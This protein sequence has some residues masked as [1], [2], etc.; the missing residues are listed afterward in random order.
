[1]AKTIHTILLNDTIA[2][3]RIVSMDNCVCQLYIITRGDDHTLSAFVDELAQPAL[4][5]LLN[6]ETRE[7]YVGETDNFPKR[8]QNHSKAKDFWT[9]AMAFFA[10]DKSLTKTEVQYLENLAYKCASEEK[11]YCLKENTQ[12]PKNPHMQAMQKIKS[13]DFFHYVQ[14]LAQSVGCFIFGHPELPIVKGK[15]LATSAPVYYC[16]GKQTHA[17]GNFNPDD[18]SLLLLKDSI[19]EGSETASYRDK[20]ARHKWLQQH[21]ALTKEHTYILLHDVPFSSP[22]TAANFA[23]GRAANG[24]TCWKNE[25]GKTIAELFNH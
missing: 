12:S 24:W 4:Y 10:N 20:D 7:A 25:D 21:A 13:D 5:V 9:V 11:A 14:M 22:S 3:S 16:N 15:K 17:M 8:L 1:M 6:D 18:N 19:L 23:L 2:G